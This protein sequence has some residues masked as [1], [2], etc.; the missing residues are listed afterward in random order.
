MSEDSSPTIVEY[1]GGDAEGHKCGYC[2][3][4]KSNRSHGNEK[5]ILKRNISNA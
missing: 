2:K 5:Y 4:P 3:S 1:F